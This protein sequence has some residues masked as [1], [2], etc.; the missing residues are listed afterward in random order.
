MHIDSALS[1]AYEEIDVN[2]GLLDVG[3]LGTEMEIE[4]R[5]WQSASQHIVTPS[6]C[7]LP[8]DSHMLEVSELWPCHPHEESVSTLLQKRFCIG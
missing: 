4:A 5:V 8:I 3:R 1:V 7:H 2:L 6:S